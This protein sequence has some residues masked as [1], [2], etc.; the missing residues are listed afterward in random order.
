MNKQ[1]S[2]IAI[3]LFLIGLISACSGSD[4]GSQEQGQ[5]PQGNIPSVE[6]VQARYGSLPLRER[7]SGT[8][9]A[10]NQVDLYPQISGRVSEV[11]VQN[12][13]FVEQGKSLVKLEDRQ[14]REQVRQARAGYKIDQARLSQARANLKEVEARYERMARLAEKDLTSEQE[15]QAVKTELE[16]ARANVQL[17]EAQ[18]EQSAATLEERREM[19]D[20]TVVK[21]PAAGHVGRRNAEAGMQVNASIRLFTLGSLD[22]VRVKVPL[23]GPMLRYVD[24]GQTAL[25]YPESN[26][27]RNENGEAL[28]AEVSRISPFL[29]TTTRT[30][31]AEIEVE[32]ENQELKPGMFVSVD[33]LYG[34]SDKATLIPSSALYTDPVTGEEGVFVVSTLGSEVQPVE[35]QEGSGQALTAPMQ[36]Q[37]KELDILARG[38]MQ[39]GVSGL[40]P[41]DWVVTVGQNLLTGSQ[42]QARVRTTTWER[43]LALQGLQRQDLLYEILR[44]QRTESSRE[45]QGPSTASPS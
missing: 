21:A 6:A 38:R 24:A 19:L 3:S 20:R 1:I 22:R 35:S 45:S 44:K 25:I 39:A 34:Q 43:I 28:S 15:L 13:D 42:P 37:F 9:E 16:S 5:A 2:Y 31:E 10:I 14:Y 4:S 29:N 26:G 33:I 8:V 17:A 11:L 36:V 12:G 41:G 18:V 32:N 40:N 23:T 27:Q 7:V 30:T